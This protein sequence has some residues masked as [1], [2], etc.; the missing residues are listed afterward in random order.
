MIVYSGLGIFFL[1]AMGL[2]GWLLGLPAVGSLFP[3]AIAMAPATA[4]L[5]ALL[6]LAALGLRQGGEGVGQRFTPPLVVLCLVFAVLNLLGHAIG[7][8]AS[9]EE[10]L[11]SRLE[12]AVGHEAVRISPVTDFF[13]LVSCLG[14]LAHGYGQRTGRTDRTGPGHAAGILGSIVGLGGLTI[15][16]GYLLGHPLLYGDGQI[17]VAATTALGFVCLG[18]AVMALAGPNRLPSSLFAGTSVRSRLMRGVVPLLVVT[19]IGSQVADIYLHHVLHINDV[20][21]LAAETVVIVA[22]AGVF[23]FRIGQSISTSLERAENAR[24]Q[25]QRISDEELAFNDMILANAPF[26]ISIYDGQTGQCVRANKTRAEIMGG[27][28]EQVLSKNFRKLDAWKASGLLDLAEKALAENVK[29]RV[30][31][32]HTT[33]CGKHRHLDCT[34]ARFEIESRPYLLLIAEDIGRR[35]AMEAEVLDKLRFIQTL[36]DA[37]ATPIYFKDLFGHYLGCNKAA[38]ELLG[39][40]CDQLIGK[41]AHDFFPPEM[42]EAFS[43]N[44]AEL[45]AKGGAQT[46]E[47]TIVTPAG[48]VRDVLFHKSLYLD[49]EKRP[50]GLIGII[51]DITDR[52]RAEREARENEEVLR[53]ILSGIRAGI[54]IIDPAQF[55]IVDVNAVAAEIIGLPRGDLIG[56]SW[57]QIGWRDQAGAHSV[58]MSCS[59]EAIGC[60]DRELFIERPDGRIVPIMKTIITADQGGKF[61][62]FE[63]FFDI[64]EQKALER[65]L[66][67]AQK[68]ESLGGLAAGIAHEINTPVQYIGDNLHFLDKA[69]ADILELARLCEDYGRAVGP[70]CRKGLE[71]LEAKKEEIDF[72]YYLDEIPK[73]V[74]QALDGVKRVAQIVL[75]MKKFSH[76]GVEEKVRSDLNEAVETTVLVSRNEWKYV[77]DVDL[78]LDR[79]QPPVFCLPGDVNQVLLNILINAAHA[80]ADKVKGTEGKG[81][82]TVKTS[83]DGEYF[84]ISI[85]DTGGGIPQANMN[86]IFDP[87]FTTKAVGKG[88]GQGLAIAH[89][90]IVGKHGGTIEVE[91][92]LGRGATFHIRLPFGGRA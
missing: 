1:S 48:T 6:A 24:L 34:L 77:A 22:V 64:S 18:A 60:I 11:V 92:E 54:C 83:G 47:T 8:D 49:S 13:F 88:T 12:Q 43:G 66:A 53:K 14:L 90:I 36:M 61:L 79:G 45:L 81:R 20:L 41:T 51:T 42:A 10:A 68:L 91:S 63:V 27:T 29:L 78:D 32:E 5:F 70:E 65:Q 89:N 25:A 19:I 71:D 46:Y 21:I 17:P 40:S 3:G 69:F 7:R 4:A 23:V 74:A 9:L 80:I 56:K 58:G 50:Q 31:L 84:K 72:S 28:V 75:A 59:L 2:A 57:K 38:V 15:F 44:D 30:D 16:W 73:A 39:V 86:R 55:T 82:I 87:F 37:A 26:G 85:S 52:K 67:M 62:A 33:S 35:K 76:P